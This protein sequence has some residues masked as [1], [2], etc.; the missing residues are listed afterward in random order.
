MVGRISGSDI[1]TDEQQVGGCGE[2]GSN[3]KAVSTIDAYVAA[4]SSGLQISGSSGGI[5]VI[6]FRI[7]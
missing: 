5:M 2:D 4:S 1:V 3:Y 6:F 7:Q